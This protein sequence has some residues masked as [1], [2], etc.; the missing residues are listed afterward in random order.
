MA[1]IDQASGWE[2]DFW[3]VASKPAGGGTISISWGGRTA[4][5][6]ADADG[7]DSNA[8]A[9]HFGLAAG[10]IRP[11]ELAAGEINHA[12]FMVVKCTSGTSVYPAGP[13]AGSACADKTNAP[14]MGQHFFL[15]MTDA[16]IEALS[17]PVLAEDD[18]A[19]DG[20]LRPLR[21][22]YRR[23]RLGDPFRVRLE[24]HQLRAGGSMGWPWATRS[25]APSRSSR[26]RADARIWDFGGAV[27]WASQ[28]PCGGVLSAPNALRCRPR[29]RTPRRAGRRVA[30]RYTS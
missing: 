8:T 5:G 4:I 9:A 19:R 24:L 3:Q 7:R 15:D 29:G 13:G 10:V 14:A 27:D 11:S 21:R 22:R 16:Q 18:P 6:T 12:L 2:Y 1:V 23:Q 17:V 30:P 20:P 28:A 26:Q 25:W